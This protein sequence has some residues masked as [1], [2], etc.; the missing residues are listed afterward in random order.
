MERYIGSIKVKVSLYCNIDAEMA[1]KATLNECLNHFPP[2]VPLFEPSRKPSYDAQ[3]PHQPTD[4]RM[5]NSRPATPEVQKL[6]RSYY[7]EFRKD[8]PI[9]SQH[10]VQWKKY[11]VYYDCYIGSQQSQRQASRDDS[12]IWWQRDGE[13]QYGQV[14]VFVEAY[15]WEAIAIVKPFKNCV[16]YNGQIVATPNLARM[17]PLKVSEIGGLAGRIIRTREMR[18]VE[19]L[20]GNWE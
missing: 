4:K 7:R 2:T 9:V 8:Y 15:D 13:R 12:Y 5:L 11:W 1:N 17:T 16:D 6:L 10:I 20:V 14:V 19:Y 18:K 3:Y